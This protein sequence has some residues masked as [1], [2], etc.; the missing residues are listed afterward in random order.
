M[1]QDLIGEDVFVARLQEMGF[2]RGE[3][4][5]LLRVLPFGDPVIVGV[6]DAWVALRKEEARCIR[7]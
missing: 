1:V 5:S 7:I 4:V 3:R 6:G 2:S